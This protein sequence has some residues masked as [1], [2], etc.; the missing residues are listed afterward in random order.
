SGVTPSLLPPVPLRN[1][2]LVEVDGLSRPITLCRP[3]RALDPSPCIATEDVQVGNSLAYLDRDGAA[4]L[5]E[6]A[7]AREVAA[8]AR[9]HAFT[10]AIGAGG[11]QAVSFA[12]PLR[13]ERPENLVF[14]GGPRL[15]VAIAHTDPS[16][17]SLTVS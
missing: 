13:F 12:W 8:L 11:G 1:V 14:S 2:L 9:G 7:P 6:H 4:H 5:A 15:E 17:F 16:P 10:L 3:L